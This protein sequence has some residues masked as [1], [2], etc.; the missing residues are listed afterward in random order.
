M[1]YFYISKVSFFF[2]CV[3]TFFVFFLASYLFFLLFL[4]LVVCYFYLIRRKL[5][6][7]ALVNDF[8]EKILLSP[9]SGKVVDFK[10]MSDGRKIIVIKKRIFDDFGL[11][12]PQ[13]LTVFDSNYSRNKRAKF[14]VYKKLWLKIQ[15]YTHHKLAMTFPDSGDLTLLIVPRLF[16]LT[17]RIWVDNGDRGIIGACFG[18]LLGGGYIIIQAP[19]NFESDV[20]IGLKLNACESI[21]G[22]FI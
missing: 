16:S 11:H 8:N 21:I 12:F 6:S 3:I 13:G 20:K 7:Y 19:S 2:L 10:L 18:M 15:S 14:V 9:A 4:I 5:L 1:K 17:P 22:R